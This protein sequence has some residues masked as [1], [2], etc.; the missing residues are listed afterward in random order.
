MVFVYN[1]LKKLKWTIFQKFPCFKQKTEELNFSLCE[2]NRD[3]CPDSVRVGRIG[4]LIYP[5]GHISAYVQWFIKKL[6]KFFLNNCPDSPL[7]HIFCHFSAQILRK[8]NKNHEIFS[9]FSTIFSPHHQNTIS[10]SLWKIGNNL[11][12]TVPVAD[13]IC[14][15]LFHTNWT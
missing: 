4:T 3:T 7:F 13:R 14:W 10:N 1:A 5:E 2:A 15:G 8:L 6:L 11:I 12:I 9:F